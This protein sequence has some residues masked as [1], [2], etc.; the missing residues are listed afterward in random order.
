MPPPPF[1]PAARSRLASLAKQEPPLAFHAPP[2]AA[3]I[4]K[5]MTARDVVALIFV[6]L[7]LPQ[8][9]SCI[10]LTAY[11]L[12]GL[13]KAM[14]GSAAARYLLKFGAA[15]LYDV[16]ARLPTRIRYLLA[17]LVGE[18]LQLCSINSIILLV[19]HY[20]LPRACLQYL[21]VLAKS[22]IAGRLVGTYA[23]GSTTY[24]SVV[25]TAPPA[26]A[27][28]PTTTTSVAQSLHSSAKPGLRYST[29]SLYNSL[30]GFVCVCLIDHI[31]N[32]WLLTLNVNTILAD[33][34][35][36]FGNIVFA[37][38][39]FSVTPQNVLRILFTK[40]PF[41]VS[42]HYLSSKK[43]LHHGEKKYLG[44]SNLLSRIAIY[45]AINYLHLGAKSVHTLSFV[46]R[47]ASVV[48]NYAYLVLCIHVITLTISPYFKSVMFFR[49]YSRT[50]DHLSSL[51]PDVPYNGFRKNGIIQTLPKDAA[52]NSAVVINVEPSQAQTPGKCITEPVEI[53]VDEK[54][55]KS[56]V[57]S[58]DMSAAVSAENYKVFCMVPP[59]SKSTVSGSHPRQSRTIIDRKRSNSNV[60]PSTTIMDKYFTVS[61]QPIWSWLAALKILKMRPKLFAG[62]PT[63]YKN[64]G[65]RFAVPAC[66]SQL[67]LAVSYIDDSKV[68]F[69]VLDRS[70]LDRV[71]RNNFKVHVNNVE[72]AFVNL[73]VDEGTGGEATAYLKVYCLTP[74]H[75]YEIAFFENDNLVGQSLV[76]TIFSEKDACLSNSIETDAIP[77]LHLSLKHTMKSLNEMRSNLKKSK[78]D[79]NK[80][81]ADLR[82]QIEA[83]KSKIGKY[84]NKD[85]SEGRVS[86]KLKG[87]QNSVSQLENEIVEIQQQLDEYEQS[88]ISFEQKYRDEEKA[89]TE[90]ILVLEAFIEK[91]ESKTSKLK[92]DAK[93]VEGDKNI[94][95]VKHRKMEGKVLARREEI[96]KLNAELRSM[97]KTVVA[98]LQKRQRKIHERFETIIP[99]I[100]EQAEC[101]THELDDAM[102]ENEPTALE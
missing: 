61:I 46:L 99:K 8:G 71:I 3:S 17:A 19:C 76:N 41:F 60:T 90:Q 63:E 44:K 15:V 31:I 16:P 48:V 97:K 80:R 27:G 52:S 100:S 34:V 55:A 91:N 82:R 6:L 73:L 28:G 32:S 29:T 68:I 81:I 20:T 9:I 49:F 86:G 59:T 50:L 35:E 33:A 14:A 43:G 25:S 30:L 96:A 53:V 22:I 57:T 67:K 93:M 65:A 83:F 75:Q 38:D 58:F 77:T 1:G 45:V 11:I 88:A 24:V 78:K 66:E 36:L 56:S 10:V 87:L 64:N 62:L 89:L 54:I 85:L 95:E 21:T 40:L 69:Q 39:V 102:T 94:T 7:M 26:T 47:E 13:F 12:L 84:T 98:K 79:E 42:Y 74:L 92:T 37:N 5:P 4:L 70:F 23:T 2:P 51:T 72:W 18:F 101:L